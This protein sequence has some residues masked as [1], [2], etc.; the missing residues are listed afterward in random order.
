MTPTDRTGNNTAKACQISLYNPDF[1]I[2]SLTTQSASLKQLSFSS[3]TS[4]KILIANPGPGNGCL[5]IISFGSPKAPPTYRT[6]SLKSLLKGSTNLN[7]KS[8]GKPPTL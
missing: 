4:P 1:L 6:S 7:C 8:F 3:V 5:F 2:S